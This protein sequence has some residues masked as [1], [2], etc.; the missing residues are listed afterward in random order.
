M[1]L[2]VV[3]D[4][5]D[6]YP[7]LNDQPVVI[8]VN[9]NHSQLVVTDGYHYTKPIELLYSKPSYYKLKIECAINDLQLLGMAFLIVF[10]YLTGFYSGW[11]LL[12]V[13][14]FLPIL[15]FLLTYYFKRKKF[16]RIVKD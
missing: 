15:W 12:K 3:I 16:I 9:E 11:L 2:R 7:L 13:F 10:F 5:K 8:A 1:K 14:S 6:I 4:G